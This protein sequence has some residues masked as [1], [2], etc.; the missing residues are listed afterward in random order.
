MTLTI[1]AD[2]E[3]GTPEWLEVR[4]GVL[5]ASTIGQLITPGRVEPSA[6]QTARALTAQLI[7]ERIT[8][9]IE[10]T[11]QTHDMLIGTLEEPRAR[12]AYEQHTG[13]EV[14]QVGF[15]L[16]ETEHL[17]LGYS[18]DGMVGDSGLI[19][20]KSRR[21]KKQLRTILDGRVPL[22]N[23]AQLQAGLYVAGREWIDYV[24]FC[25][26][27]PLFITRVEPDERWFEAIERV[28]R[29][30]ESEAAATIAAFRERTD[31][32]PV[33]EFIDYDQEIVI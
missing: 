29:D 27:M 22:E 12:M 17:R 4:R 32:M 23:M 8:G 21:P 18:P 16:L 28:A 25:G 31:G 30:F 1:H 6:S 13:V 15:I 7:S 33:P 24:S 26:G 2:L 20:I 5:T 11:P 14:E 19:E 9:R 3:Q 10:P